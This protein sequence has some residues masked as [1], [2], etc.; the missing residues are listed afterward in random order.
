MEYLWFVSPLSSE[1]SDW[2]SV[3]KPVKVSKASLFNAFFNVSVGKSLAGVH[4]TV[5]LC[6]EKEITV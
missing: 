5:S 3:Y 6:V 2:L 1:F 4:R